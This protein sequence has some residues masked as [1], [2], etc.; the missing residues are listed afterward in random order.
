MSNTNFLLSAASLAAGTVYTNDIEF[1]AGET[2]IFDVAIEAV[3]GAPSAASISVKF[4]IAQI[5]FN[6]FNIGTETNVM[7]LTW[8]DVVA[9]DGF[10]GHLLLDGAWPASLADQ[11]LAAKRVVSRSIKIPALARIV[12]LA[13]TT[14]F[15]GGT[16]PRFK[17]TCAAATASN[18]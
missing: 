12:R 15:T 5:A 10:T 2:P 4:Q 8:Q 1:D 16:A 7:P 11:T 9:G 3:S 13:I 17:V 18:E 6:G 14:V